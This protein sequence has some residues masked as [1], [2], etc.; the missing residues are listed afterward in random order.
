[1]CRRPEGTM[2]GVSNVHNRRRLAVLQWD[3]KKFA[4]VLVV[5]ALAAV[6]VVGG[7]M[8]WS[9]GACGIYW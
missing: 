6:S 7:F 2:I 8:G 5:L 3:M 4:P 9:D 1:M